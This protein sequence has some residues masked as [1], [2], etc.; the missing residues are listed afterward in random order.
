MRSEPG[1]TTVARLYYGLLKDVGVF[2]SATEKA[3]QRKAAK[4]AKDKKKAE[5]DQKAKDAAN[6]RIVESA[7]LQY[8]PP[9]PPPYNP[10]QAPA[11]ST[12]PSPGPAAAKAE[13][14][15][16]FVETTGADLEDQGVGGLKEMLARIYSAG[17]G[18]L[19]VDE[20][21]K[22]CFRQ[23]GRDIHSTVPRTSWSKQSGC[24]AHAMIFVLVFFTTVL[25]MRTKRTFDPF[26]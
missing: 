23:F 5:E 14:L 17:G 8:T 15:K 6:R 12:I 21:T 13:R 20:V 26:T 18:V 3:K 2:A 24:N 1:K 25:Q 7:G 11:P 4:D 19:F 22:R 9:P 16:G 10:P